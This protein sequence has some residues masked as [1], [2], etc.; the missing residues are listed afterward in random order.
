MSQQKVDKY[1]EEKKNRKK[2]MRIQKVKQAIGVLVVSLGIGALVGIPLGKH[3][4]KYQKAQEAKHRTIAAS[5]YDTWFE[6]KWNEEYSQVGVNEDLQK[7]LDDFN[8]ASVTD[9]S[10]SDSTAD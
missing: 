7:L 5:E 9:A 8:S 10:A 2:T 3:L 1:K 4:Y 6:E